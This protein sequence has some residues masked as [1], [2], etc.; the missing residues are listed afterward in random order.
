[1]GQVGDTSMTDQGRP[2][3]KDP[4][5]RDNYGPVA[6]RAGDRMFRALVVTVIAVAIGL[7]LWGMGFGLPNLYHEDEWRIVARAL[8]FGTG[9]LHPGSFE[10]GTLGMYICFLLFAAYALIGLAFGQF[11]SIDDFA[12]SYFVDPTPFYLIARGLFF[13][14]G[15]VSIYLVFLIGRRLRGRWAGLLAA[16]LV[17]VFPVHVFRSHL[18]F[19][20]T[21]ML[22]FM[23]GALYVMIRDREAAMNYR[24]DAIAGL[25]IG[26]GIA[27][28]YTA[29]FMGI[30]YIVWRVW[31]GRRQ[32]LN[33]LGI[34]SRLA[35][36]GFSCVIGL[37]IGMPYF[38][39]DF[40]HAFPGIVG[41]ESISKSLTSRYSA[42]VGVGTG[43]ALHEL[44]ETMLSP[45]NIGIIALV[46]GAFGL[47]VAL[48]RWPA[49]A[50]GLISIGALNIVWAL[51][52]DRLM[53]RWLF[54]TELVLCIAAGYFVV[55]GYLWLRDR[56]SAGVAAVVSV[57][58]SASLLVIPLT[59]SIRATH[60]L[61]SPDTRTL[62]RKWIETKL[63]SGTKL[64]IVGTRAYNPQPRPNED[65][66]T[67]ELSRVQEAGE[68][69]YRGLIKYCEYELEAS[70]RVSGPQYDIRRLKHNR[71][72]DAAAVYDFNASLETYVE[73]GTE[74]ILTN[75]LDQREMVMRG[76]WE[77]GAKQFFQDLSAKCDAAASFA[78][79]QGTTGPEITI[80][81][82]LA[83][84][85]DAG[86]EAWETKC[87]Y[88]PCSIV[89][90]DSDVQMPGQ[91]KALVETDHRTVEGPSG[92][93]QRE[94]MA[95]LGQ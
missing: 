71:A 86:R 43:S 27:A 19:P 77:Y 83:N 32:D 92:V 73:S 42:V 49:F 30:G 40:Q 57:I 68:G 56:T 70:R 64:L 29:V 24:K 22:C 15:L 89:A 31:E 39:L 5:S 72:Y 26:L 14:C 76:L 78:P 45:D 23:A 93:Y 20:D 52:R 6:P 16:A 79:G 74:Y 21:M 62:A 48:R 80:W 36:G 85:P 88:R 50:A 51:R 58:L 10:L 7:R 75:S 17:A 13:V 12:V 38:F 61:A 34:S 91:L 90:L 94:D 69:R 47:M 95:C 8:S 82:V 59:H 87:R 65:S 25:L 54:A 41:M 9:S 55:W 35:V 37:F 67:R 2:V 33:W 44:S 63:P 11:S 84:A 66:I 3:F 46:C 18:A 60:A 53:V 81:R 4:V 28:K 1:M